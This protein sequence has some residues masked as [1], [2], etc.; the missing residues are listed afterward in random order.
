MILTD[1][2]LNNEQTQQ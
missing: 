1:M 2:G